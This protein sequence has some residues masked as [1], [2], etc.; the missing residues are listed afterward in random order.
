MW[1]RDFDVNTMNHA[2]TVPVSRR[3]ARRAPLA[4]ALAILLSFTG[5]QHPPAPPPAS[6]AQAPTNQ[7]LRAGDVVR[8]AFPRSPALDLTQQIRRDG[9][10]NLYLVGEVTAAGLSPA[11]LEAKLV[12]GYANEVVSHEVRVTVVSSAFAVF[13]TGAVLRPGKLSAERTLTAFDAIMEAGGFDLTRADTRSVR[14]I[15]QEE[16]RA[17]TYTFNAKAILDGRAGTPFH[18]Q[19]YDTIFVPERFTWF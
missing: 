9:K 13:V 4:L 3:S 10:I 1:R 12:A 15:R 19:P 6:T 5:C 2:S 14:I 8:V 16:G 18:V 11:E 17:V 7:L